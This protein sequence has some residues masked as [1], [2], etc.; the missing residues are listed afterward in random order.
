MYCMLNHYLRQGRKFRLTLHNCSSSDGSI[1]EVF[2]ARYLFYGNVVGTPLIVF[3][4][5]RISEIAL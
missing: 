4:H 1:A 3:T 2:Q 5:G